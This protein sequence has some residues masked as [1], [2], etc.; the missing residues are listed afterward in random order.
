MSLAKAPDSLTSSLRLAAV[1]ANAYMCRGGGRLRQRFCARGTEHGAGACAVEAGERHDL[2]SLGRAHVL[3]L[4]AEQPVDA[5]DPHVAQCRAVSDR[6][7]PDAGEGQL[8]GMRQVV[9]LQH[10]GHCA[11]LGREPH[12]RRPNVGLGHLLGQRLQ[13]PAHAHVL[14]GHAHE[15]RDYLVGAQRLAQVAQDQVGGRLL[16]LQEQ[17]HEV[18]V[19]VRQRLEHLAPG[20][21]LA[22]QIVGGDRDDVGGMAAAERMRLLADQVDI[23]DKI[24]AAAD[25]VLVRHDRPGAQ[26]AQR[27]Q[28]V[29]VADLRAIHLVDEDQMRNRVRVEE[30]EQ[31]RHA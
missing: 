22:L 2:A 24:I 17:G 1:T 4:A 11:A 31:R 12:E 8:A 20:R 25:R 13:Q 14:V 28:Q 18:I 26:V 19:E 3:L 15:H 6:A 30:V 16:V 27:L 23:A 21:L 10:L 5:T 9:V 7:A 29:A